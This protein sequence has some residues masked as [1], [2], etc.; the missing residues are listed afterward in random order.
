[1]FTFSLYFFQMFKLAHKNAA[2][3]SEGRKE[4]PIYTP[5]IFILLAHGRIPHDWFLFPVKYHN[6]E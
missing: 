3:I 5:S 1:M 6:D 2:L 4:E